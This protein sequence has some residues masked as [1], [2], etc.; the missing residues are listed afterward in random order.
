MQESVAAAYLHRD[1]LVSPGPVFETGG[2]RF[3]LYDVTVPELPVPDAVETMARTFLGRADLSQASDL[4]FVV[5]HRCGADFYFLIVCSWRG[6]NEI[7]ES[8]YAKDKDDLSFRDWPRPGAHLPTFCVWE[9]GAV[10]HESQA[11]RR[12][13]LSK[14]DG[15]ARAAWL[16]DQY[17]GPI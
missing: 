10:T 2:R 13:L 6:N 7:W 16:E 9:M 8:V 17:A 3:K 11:W 15:A 14:R 4:G 5:L 1:K 12:Y